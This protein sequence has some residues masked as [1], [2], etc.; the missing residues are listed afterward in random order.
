MLRHLC[1]RG[2]LGDWEVV[3]VVGW[4]RCSAWHTGVVHGAEAERAHQE[5]KR[6]LFLRCRQSKGRW[7]LLLVT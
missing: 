4:Q 2:D 5:L 3:V 1:N 6:V 7:P